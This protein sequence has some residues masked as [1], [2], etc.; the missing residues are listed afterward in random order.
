MFE[1]NTSGI[2]AAEKVGGHYCNDFFIQN[3]FFIS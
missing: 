2:S 1:I 3:E